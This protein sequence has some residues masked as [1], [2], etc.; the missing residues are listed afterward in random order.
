MFTVLETAK[1]YFKV[2]VPQL[3]T[4]ESLRVEPS[5]NDRYH[6]ESCLVILMSSEN[7]DFRRT[8]LMPRHMSL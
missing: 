5:L 1:Q 8:A 2:G 3:I 4:S 7:E 6:S